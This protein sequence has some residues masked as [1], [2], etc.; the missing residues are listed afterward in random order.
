MGDLRTSV[1]LDLSGNLQSRAKAFS[2]SLQR[3]GHQG[4]KSMQILGRGISVADRGLQRLG[5]RYTALLTGAAGIGTFKMIGNLEERFVRL[6][7]DASAS[8]EKMDE[9]KKKIFEV[10][11]AP[12]IRLDPGQI[13]AAIELIIQ[14]TGDLSFTEENIR[15]IGLAIRAA[16][17]EGSAV[18]AVA[19][20]FQKQKF[21]AKE[22]AEAMD[23]LL[24]QGKEGAF[25]F[26][27]LASLGPR[28]FP[29]YFAATARRGVAAVKEVGAVLQAANQA[30]GEPSSTVTSFSALLRELND[31]Q[32]RKLLKGKGIKIFEPGSTKVLRSV[33]D[34]MEDVVKKTRG[35]LSQINSI[36]GDE[37]SRVFEQAVAEFQ[38]T[39][40]VESLKR[41][42]DVQADGTTMMKD[43]ADAAK[44]FNAS[45][46]YL[47]TIWQKFSD[48]H[49]SDSIKSLADSLNGL[50]SD[51]VERW[52]KLGGYIAAITGGMVVASKLGHFGADAYKLG[53]FILKG[54][55]GNAA[56]TAAGALG[57]GGMTPIPVYIVN[58]P[59]STGAGAGVG[60]VGKTAGIG[61]KVLRGVGAAAGLGT[62]AVASYE[63]GGLINQGLGGLSGILTGGKYQGKGWLGEMIYDAI[64]GTPVKQEPAEVNVN[65]GV[66]DD[67]IRVKDLNSNRRNVNADI[68]VDAGL[69]MMMP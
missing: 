15:N 48:S 52:M 63:V 41:F 64:H 11:K 26:R 27:D 9:L 25:A 46:T 6:G 24:V 4:H 43:A 47:Y 8:A 69:Y 38:N 17:A 34:I 30:I 44:T 66:G 40:N 45:L 7:I 2:G 36:F 16:G 53:K 19:A 31:P 55:G 68:D 18:G 13:L 1:I 39:G 21:I 14:K 37:A 59:G 58:A 23:V 65:I 54:K 49:L 51:T 5:N 29:S 28:I 35:S 61:G 57:G 67:R 32:K 12:D 50:N 10:A 3:L 42:L 62:M 20:E 33:P 56:A 22:V 60:V